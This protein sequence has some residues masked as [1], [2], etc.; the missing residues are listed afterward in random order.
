M[1]D[2]VARTQYLYHMHCMM[3]VWTL[4]ESVVLC[5]LSMENFRLHA[6]QVLSCQMSI[7]T[8]R[9]TNGVKHY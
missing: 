7:V 8:V 5:D 6:G 4:E 1:I 9:L 3:V 2:P